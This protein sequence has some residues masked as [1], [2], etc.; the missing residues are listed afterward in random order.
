MTKRGCPLWRLLTGSLTCTVVV[1]MR[2]LMKSVETQ[3]ATKRSCMSRTMYT[4]TRA[5]VV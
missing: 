1:L 4:C 2:G 3:N 5:D